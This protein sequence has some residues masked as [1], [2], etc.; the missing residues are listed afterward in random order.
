MNNFLLYFVMAIT[1]IKVKIFAEINVQ[2]LLTRVILYNFSAMFD[3]PY[4][5]DRPKKTSYCSVL[6]E[7]NFI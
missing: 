4:P 5:Y 1:C 6:S 2:K 7:S 3:T